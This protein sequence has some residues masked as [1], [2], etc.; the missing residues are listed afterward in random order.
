MLWPRQHLQI[1][2][3]LFDIEVK[4]QGQMNVMMIHDTLSDGHA[5]EYQISLAYLER[6]N[7]LGLN[8]FRQLYDLWIKGQGQMKVMMVLTHSF[9]VMHPN[10]KYHRPILKGKEVMTQTTFTN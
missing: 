10:T 1:I 5:P 9:R 8:K 3:P 7:K 2:L 4:G 6:Q